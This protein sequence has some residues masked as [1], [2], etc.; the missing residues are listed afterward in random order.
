MRKQKKGRNATSLRDAEI[1]RFAEWARGIPSVRKGRI[2][3]VKK[4]IESGTYDVS[5]ESV[6]NSIA[7]LHRSLKPNKQGVRNTKPDSLEPNDV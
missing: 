3:A 4:Q 5:A 1:H 2:E 7:D 6:A